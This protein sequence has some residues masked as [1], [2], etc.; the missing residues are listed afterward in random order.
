[1]LRAVLV[2]GLMLLLLIAAVFGPR[3]LQTQKSE[4][5]ATSSAECNLDKED[6]SWSGNSGDWRVSLS[7]LDDTAQGPEY[8]LEVTTSEAPDR[9][10]GVLR[11]V[12]MYMG[13]YPVPL[14]QQA[15][16][17][18]LAR[19]TAPFCT[20]GSDMRWRL[21]LQEGQGRVASVPFDMVFQAHTL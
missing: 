5:S 3:L 18:Y 19:F 6:C 13:E 9:L 16:G 4:T 10:L 2:V 8:E 17:V 1:M 21:D 11:G 14:E 12:S 7:P 15:D 20:T